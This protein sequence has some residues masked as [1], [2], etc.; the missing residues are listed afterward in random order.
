[1]ADARQQAIRSI[2]ARYKAA[3][4]TR[5]KAIKAALKAFHAYQAVRKLAGLRPLPE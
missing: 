4:A 3:V 1:M 5:D 2:G